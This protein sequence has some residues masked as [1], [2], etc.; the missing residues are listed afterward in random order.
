VTGD[1]LTLSAGSLE[2][3]LLPALGGSVVVFDRIAGDARQPLL[4]GAA[5]D[6]ASVLD[7]ACFPLVPYANRIRGGAFTCDGREVRLAPN[8]PG[9]PSPLH[10]Q[11]WQNAWTVVEATA[12]RAVLAYDHPAGEWPWHYRATQEIALDPGGLSLTL[13]CRNLSSAAMPCGLGFHPYYPCDADTLLDTQVTAAWTVDEAVLPVERVPAT[14]R[15][16]LVQ[17]R[18]CGQ[19]LD[20]GYDGWSGSATIIWPAK[21]AALRLSSSDAGRFQ[22][23]SPASGGVFVAEPVQNANAALNA[24]QAQWPDLGLALLAE[25]EEHRLHARFDVLVA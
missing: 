18:I 13:S 3:Q 17:R 2:V 24:P 4:R 21:S 14:G 22:V 8:M 12:T 15:Y 11:G 23:Y 19:G 7:S 9:D 10:G 1:R 6:A 16:D 5:G 25:G 20:N